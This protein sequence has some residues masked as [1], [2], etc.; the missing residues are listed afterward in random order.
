MNDRLRELLT[1]TGV[2]FEVITHPKRYTAQ[3]RAA[4]SRITGHRLTKVIVLRDGDW[5]GLAVLPAAASLDLD[6]VR[7]LTG[8]P[9]LTL[10][11]E[12]DF[13]SLFPDC[14]AGAM[15]P[16]GRLYGLTTF[17]DSALA[18]EPE[19]VFEAGSHDEEIRMPTGAY[20]EMEKPAIAS[21]AAAGRR[22]A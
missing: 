21:L 16:F 10:A 2:T 18:D 8:R 7:R 4:V 14:D 1:R 12:Q 17:L 15:P 22:A 5:F 9:G 13:A 19:L 11:R 6:Q 3:E 20:L